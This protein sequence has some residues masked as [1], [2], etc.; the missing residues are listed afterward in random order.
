M[1]C[2]KYEKGLSKG[3]SK[4]LWQQKG[5][6]MT[7]QGSSQRRVHRRGD[8]RDFRGFSCFFFLFFFF[9]ILRQFWRV[10]GNL[11]E[12]VP[13]LI[14]G[15]EHLCCVESSWTTP[16]LCTSWRFP[17]QLGNPPHP[18]VGLNGVWVEHEGTWAWRDGTRK[19]PGQ[20]QAWET[21]TS[22]TTPALSSTPLCISLHPAVPPTACEL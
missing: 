5:G 18:S 21:R 7:T 13:K 4:L 3:I 22:S 15:T 9:R 14:P 20:V 8:M 12:S 10:R 16:L 6:K 2:I 1:N 17:R 19:K 11:R